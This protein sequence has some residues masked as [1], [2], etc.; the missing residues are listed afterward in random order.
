M[1]ELTGATASGNPEK[2][3]VTSD[4]M[5]DDLFDFDHKTRP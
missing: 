4:L 1:W 3:A 2:A 5:I